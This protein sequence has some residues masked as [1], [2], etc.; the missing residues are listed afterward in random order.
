MYKIIK[1]RKVLKKLEKFLCIDEKR[2]LLYHR[3]ADGICSAA[4]LIKFFGSFECIPRISPELEDE[5]VDEIIDKKPKLLVFVDLAVDQEWKKIRRIKKSLPGLKIVIIDH[6]IPEKNL[7]SKNIIH[8]NPRFFQDAY[9]AASYIVYRLLEMMNKNVK[10]YIWIAA[11]GTIGDYDLSY[12]EDILRE[13]EELYPGS[14][15]KAPLTSK[16]GYASE[17]I[18]SAVTLSGSEGAQ[19]VLKILVKSRNYKRFISSKKIG[20]WHKKVR[21]EIRRVVKYAEKHSEIHEDIG[22]NIYL[23]KTRLNLASAVSTFFGEK[24]PDRVVIV[25]KR[26]EKGWKISLR[27]QSGKINVGDL[28]RRCSSGIGMGGGH[29]KAAGASV[30]DWREFKARVIRYLK[31]IKR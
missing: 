3:D 19:M 23:I 16:L 7:N 20:A 28:A 10:P 1:D 4:L 11:I 21:E 8:I 25:R 26:Y 6:H 14:I 15:G 22:L 18:C 29:V 13:C 12:S 17:L 2:I 9:L 27:N 31:L 30:K 24:N 5:F